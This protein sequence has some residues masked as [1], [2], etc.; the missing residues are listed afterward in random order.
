MQDRRDSARTAAGGGA[1]QERNR[2][3]VEM[4]FAEVPPDVCRVAGALSSS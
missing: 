1:R 3:G 4:A 2:S